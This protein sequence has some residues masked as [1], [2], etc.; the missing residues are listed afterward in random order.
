MNRKQRVKMIVHVLLMPFTRFPFGKQDF[1]LE[2]ANYQ[3]TL[4]KHH[5]VGWNEVKNRERNHKALLHTMLEETKPDR[6]SEVE[7]LLEMFYPVGQMADYLERLQADGLEGYYFDT[8]LRI[9]TEMITL[10]D[11]R[12][13]IKM[14]EPPRNSGEFFPDSSGLYKVE[15]WSEMARA[16]T[17]DIFIAGY[18]VKCGIQDVSYL[19]NVPDNIFLSDTILNKISRSGLAETH[20]HLSAGMSYQSVW[21]VVTD[22]SAQRI[23][24]LESRS[25]YQ[26]QQLQEQ[27]EHDWLMIAGWLRLL[28]AKYLQEIEYEKEYVD[29][30]TFYLCSSSFSTNSLEWRVIYYILHPQTENTNELCRFLRSKRNHCM[31]IMRENFWVQMSDCHL[32]V[33]MRGPYQR[34]HSLGTSGE[35]LLLFFAL[36]HTQ[37]FPMHHAFQKV[38]LCYLRI[39]NHYFQHK[40]QSTGTGGLTFFREYFSEATHSL[41][42]FQGEDVQKRKLAYQAAFHNQ[43]HC[44]HLTKLEVKIAPPAP[45]IQDKQTG[46]SEYRVSIC[47]Q[48]IEIFGAYLE[49]LIHD[50]TSSCPPTL[51]IV[52]HFTRN[53]QN[54]PTENT[55][56]VIDTPL[57]PGDSISVLRRRNTFFFQGLRH[58]MDHIPYLSEYVVGLDVA[59]EEIY[60]E[61]WIYAPIYYQAR[62]RNNTLPIQLSTGRFMQNIGFTYHVGEDYYHVLSGLRHIDE[63]LTHFG[64]KAGDRIGHGTALHIDLAKWIHNNE[65]V[66]LPIMEYME[67]LLWLWSL[68]SKNEKTFLE[69]LPRLE[70]EILEL[71]QSIYENT[72]GITPSV[73]W[74]AYQK[75]FQELDAD[76]C[77]KMQQLYFHPISQHE[78]FFASRQVDSQR[79]FCTRI[80]HK[81]PLDGTCTVLGG[82]SVW[83]AEKLLLTHYCPCYQRCYSRPYFSHNSID[84]LPLY[85]A[86]QKYVRKKVEEMGIYIETNPTS[87]LVIGDIHGLPEYHIDH[88][89]DPLSKEMPPA[90]VLLSV[91]S[92]DPLVFN[93]NVENELAL[94]YHLL[95]YRQISREQVINW[96]DKIRKYGLDSS[97]IRKSK[98]KHQQ[99][100]ELKKIIAG[101]TAAKNTLMEGK[102]LS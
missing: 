47:K 75:K 102:E 61:P 20:L 19:K 52:Y 26:K 13:S 60:D 101:L 100:V 95:L 41:R 58:L 83:D 40:I 5:E 38:L 45:M 48:L 99:I 16:V 64:Y 73:L 72:K 28:M 82:D 70:Q 69:Y 74:S 4:Q 90:S 93:T 65:V 55:C 88:L 86:V 77:R 42:S 37:R 7:E 34:Y 94:V 21:E 98:S 59:S 80:W 12:V 63:V 62:N 76:F 17:P 66:S 3:R 78:H 18:F 56:W 24:E 91:N 25:N 50:T 2:D 57:G 71:A 10:R 39:K 14:W 33:L 87:N 44:E 32:D 27:K 43:L 54:A 49:I 30:S 85:Q 51:G 1:L 29:I 53:S 96:I 35:M 8:L 31:T 46:K 81:T 11:G 15:L 97:F 22:P 79:S 36:H 68:C 84:K 67:N 6:I 9:S 23:N 89:N 92:D